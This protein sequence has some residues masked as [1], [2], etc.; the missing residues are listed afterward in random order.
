MIVGEQTAQRLE[1]VGAAGETMQ[2]N[3]VGVVA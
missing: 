3:G 2:G 1:T